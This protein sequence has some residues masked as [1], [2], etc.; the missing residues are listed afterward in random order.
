MEKYWKSLENQTF[1]D[2]EVVVVDDSSTDDTY[3]R[4]CNYVE[5]SPLRIKLLRNSE[6]RGPGYTRNRGMSEAKGDWITFV[7]S[8]DSVDLHLLEKVNGIIESNNRAAVPINCVVYDYNIVKGNE[9]SRA[10]SMYGSYRGGVHE[11]S[12]CIAMV[13]NH[14]IGK[15]YKS[16][17]I[18]KIS[19]PELKRCEDVAFVCRAIEACCMDG[20]KEIG[21][22]YYLKEALYNYDQRPGSLSNDSTLDATD[23]IKAYQIITE[24]LGAKYPEEIETKAIPDLLYGGVLIKCKANKGN[25]EIRKYIED[26]E[27]H[28]PNWYKNRIVKQLGKAKMV[29]LVCIKYR[30]IRLL[31]SLAKIHSRLIG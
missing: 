15:F 12:T 6:N 30:H 10:S 27:F 20:D 23:M 24:N 8:D 28:Y 1:T 13:R 21:C 14:V 19:F 3:I 17:R 31:K 18:K 26:F 29:F 16:E 11:I 25:Q 5:N 9:V 22:T 4:L 7:D 2:F